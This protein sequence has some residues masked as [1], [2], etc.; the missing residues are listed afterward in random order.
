[1]I[2]QLNAIGLT[3]KRQLDDVDSIVCPTVGWVRSL[4]TTLTWTFGAQCLSLILR[5]KSS[6]AALLIGGTREF[7][8]ALSLVDGGQRGFL[9]PFVAILSKISARTP[10]MNIINMRARGEPNFFHGLLLVVVAKDTIQFVQL[11]LLNLI[12]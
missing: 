3:K 5:N 10:L 12:I 6:S 7:G 8:G 11:V 2:Y 9:E 4:S 1:M